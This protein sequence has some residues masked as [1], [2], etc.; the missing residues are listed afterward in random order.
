MLISVLK[1]NGSSYEQRCQDIDDTLPAVS[2]DI[3]GDGSVLVVGGRGIRC[4]RSYDWNGTA[5]IRRELTCEVQQGS[6]FDELVSL[7]T[8]GLVV[9]VSTIG[10]VDVFEWNGSAYVQRGNNLIAEDEEEASVAMNA[11]GSIIAIG[12]TNRVS[13]FRWS[14]TTYTEDDSDIS[15]AEVVSYFARIVSS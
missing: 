4:F 9:S 1:W 8:N 14:G 12:S 2:V 5:Y 6:L 3:G 7:S 15:T 13:M 10:H 11:N